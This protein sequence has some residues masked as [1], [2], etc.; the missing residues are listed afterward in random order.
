MSLVGLQVLALALALALAHT[1]RVGR[2]ERANAF[3]AVFRLRL[4]VDLSA[5]G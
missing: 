1:R 5:S 4:T 2:I 3:Q